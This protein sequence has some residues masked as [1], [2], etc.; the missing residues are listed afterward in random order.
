M[1][2]AFFGAFCHRNVKTLMQWWHGS[3]SLFRT[4]CVDECLQRVCELALKILVHHAWR[5]STKAD[6]V[7]RRTCGFDVLV[8][9][10]AASS[11]KLSATR[12]CQYA[13]FLKC[14]AAGRAIKAL[15]PQQRTYSLRLAPPPVLEFNN[16][17]APSRCSEQFLPYLF[18]S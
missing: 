15:F 5:L 16:H 11:S 18:P 12:F 7:L 1:A 14:I 3:L 17:D 13:L 9:C 4:M 8:G 10:A 2:S 6:A